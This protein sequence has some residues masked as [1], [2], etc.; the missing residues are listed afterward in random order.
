MQDDEQEDCA[1]AAQL[2]ATETLVQRLTQQ[3]QRADMMQ[4]QLLQKDQHIV[5][6]NLR[7]ADL[8][9]Q[10]IVTHKSHT[11]PT[12]CPALHEMTQQT[13]WR[14][15]AC[16]VLP[17][18]CHLGS[19]RCLCKVLMCACLRQCGACCEA[20]RQHAAKGVVHELW[21]NL[22]VIWLCCSRTQAAYGHWLKRDM[23]MPEGDHSALFS[24]T[25]ETVCHPLRL[26]AL[27]TTPRS[28]L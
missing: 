20:A 10:V 9:G 22:L 25:S 21:L 18:V 15:K 27:L 3:Q 1:T 23:V 26:T 17:Y 12:W 4:A 11:L 8:E 7:V 24:M 28:F 19:C 16:S 2:A 5:A 6:L 13:S 14:S